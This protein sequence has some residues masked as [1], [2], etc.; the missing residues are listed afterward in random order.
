LAATVYE[1]ERLR[2]L[3][4]MKHRQRYAACR[5]MPHPKFA[6]RGEN[7]LKGDSQ[8]R[9]SAMRHNPGDDQRV[10]RKASNRSSGR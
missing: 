9:Y 1:L 4:L 10:F 6:S 8:N 2:C 3:C 7:V 5:T